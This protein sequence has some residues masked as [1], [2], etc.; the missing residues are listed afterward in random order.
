MGGAEVEADEEG[1]AEV[2]LDGGAIVHAEDGLEEGAV[3]AEDGLE[4][5]AD[6]EL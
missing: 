6:G 4:E 3:H 2:K 5:G 1:D